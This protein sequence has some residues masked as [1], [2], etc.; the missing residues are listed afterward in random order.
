L[1]VL[2]VCPKDFSNRPVAVPVDVRRELST[3]RRQLSRMTRVEE[4]LAALPEG[5]TFDLVRD[6]SGAPTRPV[7][8]LAEAVAAVPAAY[9]PECIST[10][11]LGFHCR[12]QARCAGAVEQ[13]G[14]GVRGEL[15]SLRTV[16]AALAAA[17][18]GAEPGMEPALLAELGL[19]EAS[20]RLAYAARLRAEALTA[21][22]VR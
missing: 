9:G 1:T 12:A 16:E 4:L 11:E 21:G 22:G 6:D 17:E 18:R 8:E 13:L 5:V 19:D 14:R 20:E 7:G 3:T 15:G 2:L 10:C